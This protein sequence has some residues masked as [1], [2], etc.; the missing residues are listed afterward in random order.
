MG[1]AA[2]DAAAVVAAAAAAVRRRQR[3]DQRSPSPAVPNELETGFQLAYLLLTEP[4]I[5][6]AGFEQFKTHTREMLAGDAQE[7]AV[8]GTRRLRRGA[9]SRRRSR[10]LKPVT[11]EQIDRLTLDAAQAWLEQADRGIADRGRDR[12]RHLP[13]ER[14]IE[15]VARYLGSLPIARA[16]SP[17]MYADAAQARAPG[18]PAR[19]REDD[20]HADAA[21]VRA[22]AGST[23]PTRRN[24]PDAARADRW[25][26]AIL[27]TRMVK[28]V[29]EE[30]QL[31][32]SIGAGSRAGTTY[33][34]FGVFSAAAPTDPRQGP[35]AGRQA[36]IDVRD[37]RQGRPDRGGD[38]RR[39]EAVRQHLRRAAQGAELLVRPPEPAHVPRHDPRRPRRRSPRRTR[40]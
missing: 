39:Q 13:K 21:G 2:A 8:M 16:S 3:C 37:V 6:E 23:A 24:R 40:R 17:K 4:K 27:S 34:G 26:R 11:V 20:R 29:R 10:A 1:S 7:P 18:R 15:L 12:R 14:A 22:T 25:P 35:A 9:V 28:E 31:V 36:R 19:V 33:P 32:Y 5:E 30:A 38:D